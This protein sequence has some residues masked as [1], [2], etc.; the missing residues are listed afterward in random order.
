[1]SQGRRHQRRPSQSVFDFPDDF[2]QPPP[3]ADHGGS[4][5]EFGYT[6]SPNKIPEHHFTRQP[7]NASVHLKDKG[8]ARSLPPTSQK[9]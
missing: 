4:A 1:M 3:A 6:D 2:L 5:K 7:V 9:K 8:V